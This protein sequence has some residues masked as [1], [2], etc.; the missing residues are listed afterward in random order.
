MSGPVGWWRRSVS[1]R[2][3]DA[4]SEGPGLV[5]PGQAA[6]GEHVAL[7][8]VD[9]GEWHREPDFPVDLD[10]LLQVGERRPRR[11]RTRSR[12]GP[13]RS[14]PR[15]GPGAGPGWA[16]VARS[17]PPPPPCRRGRRNG[18]CPRRCQ[19]AMRA[20]RRCPIRRRC[21]GRGARSRACPR[22]RPGPGS[23]PGP[24]F[25]RC[26]RFPGRVRGRS[27]RRRFRW[28]SGPSAVPCGSGP[29]T[30]RGGP[31]SSAVLRRG[32]GG[33][34]RR[35]ESR[36]RRWSK[37]AWQRDPFLTWV[38]G[39]QAARRR[40]ADRPVSYLAETV[41]PCWFPYLMLASCQATS[42]A[43]RSLLEP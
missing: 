18:S 9:G 30:S 10:E 20:V 39:P 22:R 21:T 35:A 40:L 28:C 6:V 29:P 42:P 38:G 34:G 11:R 8:L 36:A 7:G 12:S 2:S 43:F 1:R 16:R 13:G 17:I 4:G 25:R 32:C 26:R 33:A 14:V 15:G 31:G 41:N 5:Q 37:W 3:A 19:R 27:R 24:G 23:A